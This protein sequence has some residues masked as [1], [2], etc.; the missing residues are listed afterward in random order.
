[1][2]YVSQNILMVHPHAANSG[3][4]IPNALCAKVFHVTVQK[5]KRD[6]NISIVLS[7]ISG[8]VI[9]INNAPSLLKL[10][11]RQSQDTT[12]LVVRSTRKHT[13]MVRINY[14]RS[15]DSRISHLLY[16]F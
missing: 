1:M 2:E 4:S 9:D 5:G 3:L 14:V 11:E 15:N 7:E 16:I 6:G 10:T 12:K 8:T 13:P